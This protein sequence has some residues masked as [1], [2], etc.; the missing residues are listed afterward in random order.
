MKSLS[1]LLFPSHLF[2][3]VFCSSFF[4][5]EDFSRNNFLLKAHYVLKHILYVTIIHMWIDMCAYANIYSFFLNL[6]QRWAYKTNGSAAG[7]YNGSFGR[8][9]QPVPY[10]QARQ[11]RFRLKH[12]LLHSQFSSNPHF[13]LEPWHLLSRHF[14]LTLASIT[15]TVLLLEYLNDGSCGIMSEFLLCLFKEHINLLVYDLY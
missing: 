11:F 9:S 6:L 8:S 4:K 12:H 10:Q 3:K 2:W 7:W 5:T 1:V 13:S 15:L 14:I